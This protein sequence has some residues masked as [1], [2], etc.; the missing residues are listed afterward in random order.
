MAGKIENALKEWYGIEYYESANIGKTR[1]TK[2]CDSCGSS[3]PKG[4]SHL[5]YRFYGEDS[6]WPVF[7][8]CNAC[9]KSESKDLHLIEE[10]KRGE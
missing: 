4:S 5:G 10:F 8:V 9:E 2:F 1:G 7:I 3:I 6:A